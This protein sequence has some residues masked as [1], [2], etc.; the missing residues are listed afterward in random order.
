MS[1][2][3]SHDSGHEL[4]PLPPAE[5]IADPGL[6]PHQP[7]PTDVDPASERRAE[8]QVAA[9]FLL[10]ALLS[11]AFGV[12][13]FTAGLNDTFL[14]LGA[15]TL[16]LGLTLGLSLLCIGIG[17]I[18]W[19]RK[20]MTDEEIVEYRHSASSSEEDREEECRRRLLV[21]GEAT[22]RFFAGDEGTNGLPYARHV[23]PEL[24]RTPDGHSTADRYGWGV[25]TADGDD[26]RELGLWVCDP[27]DP[28]AGREVPVTEYV[29]V[30]ANVDRTVKRGLSD[31]FPVGEH[32][33]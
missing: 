11:V 23:E 8:R 4:E 12:A 17:A 21:E 16:F 15:S 32:L 19:A 2:N 6:P 10:A 25:V 14:G 7:R 28:G 13:Y 22:L 24:I 5:P 29:R 3:H 9:F 18:Q 33:R 30:K 1:E 31:L 26:E 27:A 20:L